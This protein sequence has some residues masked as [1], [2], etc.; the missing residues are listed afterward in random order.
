MALKQTTSRRSNSKH[1][2]AL[3]M[4][5][6]VQSQSKTLFGVLQSVEESG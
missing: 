6:M 5:P 3:R 4:H 2:D 1:Y